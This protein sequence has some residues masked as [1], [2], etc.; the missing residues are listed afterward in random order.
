MASFLFKGTHMKTIKLAEALLRRKELQAKVDQLRNIN[1]GSLFE[2]KGKRAKVTDEVDDIV[3]QVPKLYAKQVTE[4]YDFYARSLRLV[5]A[6]IQQTNWTAD[7]KVDPDCMES[8][9]P[10][11]EIQEYK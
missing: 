1:H 2:V 10:G 7:V 11:R 6:A 9:K 5:D 8:Y 3:V 4:E